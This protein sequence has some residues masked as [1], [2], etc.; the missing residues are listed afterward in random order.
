MVFSGQKKTGYRKKQ[1]HRQ[2]K[3]FLQVPWKFFTKPYGNGLLRWFCRCLKGAFFK[4]G[5]SQNIYFGGIAW[6]NAQG[7]GIQC[8]V[9]LLLRNIFGF[10]SMVFL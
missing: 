7:A 9:F 4:T 6:S 3:N 5:V 1:A 8:K 10:F 2:G